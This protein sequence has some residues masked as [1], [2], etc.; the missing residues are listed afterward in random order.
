M[1]S[2]VTPWSV[3]KDE[4]ACAEGRGMASEMVINNGRISST[5]SSEGGRLRGENRG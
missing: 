5:M 2:A 4:S 1:R 3:P